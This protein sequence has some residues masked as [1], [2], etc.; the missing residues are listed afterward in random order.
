MELHFYAASGDERARWT[1]DRKGTVIETPPSISADRADVL[2]E[3]ARGRCPGN[4]P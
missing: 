2:A 4:M 1:V 3:E